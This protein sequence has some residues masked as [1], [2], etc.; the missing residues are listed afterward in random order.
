MFQVTVDG[1]TYVVSR[2]LEAQGAEAVEAFMA[3]KK[4][5]PKRATKS[6]KPTEEIEDENAS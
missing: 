1:K 6:V 3:S 5:K 4:S 2:E